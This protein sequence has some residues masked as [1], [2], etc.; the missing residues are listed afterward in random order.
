MNAVWGMDD[1]TLPLIGALCGFTRPFH[2]AKALTFISGRKI[3]GGIAFHNWTPE[4]GVIEVTAASTSPKWFSRGILKEITGYAFEIC[5]CHAM[6]ARTSLD[7]PAVRIW[8]A[9]GSEEVHIPHLRGR[10]EPE[11]VFVLTDDAWQQSK[12]RK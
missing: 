6:V 8:R 5:A 4:N 1:I 10:G 9:L 2:N 7:N 12:F 3:V 11:I